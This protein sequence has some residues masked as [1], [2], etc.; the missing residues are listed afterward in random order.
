MSSAWT[1]SYF[2]FDDLANRIANGEEIEHFTS[3]TNKNY[4]TE[5]QLVT[6]RNRT[7]KV[8]KDLQK[9]IDK[10]DPSVSLTFSLRVAAPHPLR[11]QMS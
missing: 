6:I 2:N 1:F 3:L 8:A 4:L 7:Y 11:H 5:E 9:H 10:I